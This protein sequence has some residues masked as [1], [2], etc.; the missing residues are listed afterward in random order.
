MNEEILRLVNAVE[1]EKGVEREVIF[2]SLEQAI[3]VAL[4]RQL[5]M[6]EGVVVAIDR[7]NGD[8][9]ARDGDKPIDPQIIGRLAF[10]AARQM[11]V[12]KLREAESDTAFRDFSHRVGDIV[13]CTLLRMDGKD[14]ICR[15]GDRVEARLAKKDQVPG[16]SF[17]PRD[18]FKALITEVEKKS[19][20]VRIHLT[21]GSIEFVRKL[22]ELEVPEIAEGV[23]EL[24]KVVREPGYRTKVAVR[25]RKTK[26]DCLGACVGVRGSRI[27]NVVDELNGE[28]IDVI[29]WSD[30]PGELIK[31][32]LKPA[33]VTHVELEGAEKH[34]TVWVTKEE[35]SQAI[36]RQGRNVRLASELT[37]WEIDIYDIQEVQEG[38]EPGEG[39]AGGAKGEAG[40]AV[41]APPVESP[42]P[43]DEGTHEG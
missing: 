31:N 11:F 27:R 25:S 28:N 23:V 16:E 29:R 2:A 21:R 13:S 8:I 24:F 12:Q 32:S 6:K 41:A 19:A 36:G 14:M 33:E 42:S 9:S 20:K 7:K 10:Q 34:A 37:G 22:F 18:R 4:R 26:V 38:Q 17:R 35:L 30:E 39:P 3:A 5:G 1:K 15:V 43:K 40:P